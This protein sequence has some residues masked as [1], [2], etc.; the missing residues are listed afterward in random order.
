MTQRRFD[1]SSEV[2]AL[3]TER[4]IR[5]LGAHD[6]EYVLVGGLAALAQGST[7]ATADADVLPQLDTA[8]L[9]RLLDALEE[10]RA[11][12]LVGEKR[13]AMEAGDPWEAMELNGRG[14][15]ALMDADAWHYHRRRTG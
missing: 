2:H 12:L 3:D 11:A 1:V 10:L 14:A 7:I 5:V 8:N 13:Q 4:I 15:D 6:V 9:E